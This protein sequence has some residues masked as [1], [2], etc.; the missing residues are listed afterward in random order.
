MLEAIVCFFQ[1][2]F[3]L[4]GYIKNG[5][6]FPEPLS[7]EEER[8]AIEK[9]EQGDEEARSRLIEHNLRLVAH[10]AKKYAGSRRDTDDLISIGSIGLIKA[11]ST[12][13]RGRGNTMA[14]YASKCIENEILMSL[15]AEKKTAWEVSLNEAIGTDKDG[16]EIALAD[17]L[18]S[19]PDQT[20]NDAERSINTA[21]LTEMI[22]SRL[23]PREQTVIKLRYGIP[24]GYAMPQREVAAVLGISRSYVSRLEKKA[25]KKLSAFVMQER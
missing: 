14:T 23:N 9:L 24:G 19:D 15:R 12:Y 7:P 20:H 10:I 16:N 22:E 13:K 6:A 11:V 1:N 4:V 5:S 21:F 3:F 2:L 8:F 17:I 25:L 18:G